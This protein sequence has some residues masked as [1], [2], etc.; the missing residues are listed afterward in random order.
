MQTKKVIIDAYAKEYDAVCKTI[1]KQKRFSR[2]VNERSVSENILS[3]NK[4]WCSKT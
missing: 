2:Y 1:R 3:N 4:K